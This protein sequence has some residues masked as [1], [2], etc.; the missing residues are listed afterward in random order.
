[1]EQITLSNGVR[2]LLEQNPFARSAAI[3]FHIGSGSCYEQGGAMGASHF[4]EHM[5]FKGTPTR[6]ARELAEEVDA[7]GGQLNAYTAKEYTCLFGQALENHL[8]GLVDVMLDLLRSPKLAEDDIETEKSVILEEISMVED[9][10]E[11]LCSDKLYEKVFPS[12]SL[13][14]NILGT[15]ETVAGMTRETL[16]GHMRAFYTPERI[17]AAVSGRFDRD[18]L[19]MEIERGLG[20]MAPAGNPIAAPAVR[21]A[22]GVVR[23]RRRVEQTQLLLAFPAPAVGDSRRYALA[24]LSNILG[25][26]ASSR[27]NQRIREELGL[28][29]AIYSFAASHLGGGMFGV[30]AGV[31]HEKQARVLREIL[32]ILRDF[33]P[34]LMHAE[35]SRTKE[36]FKAGVVMGLESSASRASG[37]GRSVLLMNEYQ[38]EDEVLSAIDAVSAH[39]VAALAAEL[40]RLDRAA[41]AVVGRPENAAF[42]R[43]I[44]HERG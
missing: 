44:L 28:C 18:A 5:L 33:P 8:P 20:D 3:T 26:G 29:Y 23:V 34:E 37:M 39:D 40:L 38:D 6:G 22:P 32:S 35:L 13:G 24:V 9:T 43:E 31:A 42:Y 11:E 27:L 41:L 10:P 4:V 21:F 36:Q 12:E 19:L 2:V 15:R 30:S 14:S 25:G 17:T 1:M 16:L 7:M